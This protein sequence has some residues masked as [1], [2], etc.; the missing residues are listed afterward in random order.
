MK[1]IHKRIEDVKTN[2][3][4]VSYHSEYINGVQILSTT[5]AQALYNNVIR[6]CN[7]DSIFVERFPT[8]AVCSFDFIDFQD[9]AE[10][11]NSS[12]GYMNKDD[13]GKVWCLDKDILIHK[14]K[15]YSPLTCCFVPTYVNNS[16]LY[17]GTESKHPIGVKKSTK[18]ISRYNARC[19]SLN[20]R[21]HI[22]S[23]SSP[24][25]AHRAWQVAKIQHLEEVVIK[26]SSEVDSR[27]DVICALNARIDKLRIEHSNGIETLYV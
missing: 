10:W 24:A 16:L 19:T 15:S 2:G 14:N 11:C 23:F 13:T 26:Y 18:C 3:K 22:G 12:S 6:R 8:Y 21:K 17:T 5:N 27:P 9:F 4:W 20:R 1:V 7:K 25:L